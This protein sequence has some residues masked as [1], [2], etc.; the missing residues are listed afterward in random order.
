MPSLK[1]STWLCQHSNSDSFKAG[2]ASGSLLF[3]T[4]SAPGTQ[5]PHCRGVPSIPHSPCQDMGTGRKGS[6]CELS[7]AHSSSPAPLA[8]DPALSH[9]PA[10]PLGRGSA[11]LSLT[12]PRSV[13]SW[14]EKLSDSFLNQEGWFGSV[15]FPQ[16]H[17]ASSSPCWQYLGHCRAR[18][19]DSW[20]GQEQELLLIVVQ[21]LSPTTDHEQVRK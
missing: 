5:Q 20:R 14:E 1:R 17:S 9:W 7:Q 11:T 10:Q 2:G 16:P 18:D 12:D 15:C 21:L 3:P 19:G 8:S 6:L 4:A 13:S